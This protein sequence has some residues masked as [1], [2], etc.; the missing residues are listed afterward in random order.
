MNHGSA[1]LSLMNA[2]FGANYKF[3]FI[4][5]HTCTYIGFDYEMVSLT[6]AYLLEYMHFRPNLFF[7]VHY[8]FYCT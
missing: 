6:L 3:M 8:N 5:Y 2:E 4:S 7:I 1:C